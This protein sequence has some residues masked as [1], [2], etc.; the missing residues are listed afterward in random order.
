VRAL[1][2]YLR[3]R[4]PVS[5]DTMLV[6]ASLAGLFVLELI[7]TT[8]GEPPALLT[9]LATT[10]LLGQPYL[11]LR[12][13]AQ[14]RPVSRL[15]LTAALVGYLLTAVPLFFLTPP[16]P[17]VLSLGVIAVFVVTEAVTAALLGGE[18]RRRTGAA[19]VRMTIAALATAA[20]AV[21]ILVAGASA[22][23]PALT[24]VVGAVTRLT[25]LLAAL[26]Y[27]AA[28]VPPHWLRRIWQASAAYGYSQRLL[29]T[30]PVEPVGN[31]W[32]R[33]AETAREISGMTAAAVIAAAD[34]DS[35]EL[36]GA[37]GFANQPRDGFSRT[38]W[39]AVLG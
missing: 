9:K 29:E 34:A 15:V 16:L 37:A 4:A 19:R 25:A 31:I 23:N 5:R 10:L 38:E 14:L 32:S 22:A 20:F 12:L 11:T 33:F 30:P 28:F 8:L 18:A 24:D 2:E 1:I 26:G 21:A 27:V 13:V 36:L 3:R 35:V 6:F 39:G 17:V 7:R